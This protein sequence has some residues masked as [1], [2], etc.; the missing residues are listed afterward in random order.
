MEEGLF[1]VLNAGE[2]EQ[3]VMSLKPSKIEELGTEGWL[4]K[5]GYMQKLHQQAVLEASEH[6]EEV[7]KEFMSTYDKVPVL[8]HDAICISVWRE[9]VLPEILKIE[10][11]PKDTFLVYSV[12]F[13]EATSVSL[14][15]TVLFHS[16]S[17]EALGDTAVDLLDYCMP[18]LFQVANGFKK[19]DESTLTKDAI[20]EQEALISF[21][22]GIRC[23]SVLHYLI[24]SMDSL[25][26][27]VT[28]RM[29]THHDVPLLLVHLLE[30]HPWERD[31]PKICGQKL[32]FI[33][34]RWVQVSGEDLLKLTRVEGQVW[35]A[36]RQLLLRESCARNYEF[37]E[38]RKSQLQKV[39]RYMT[40][41]LL[42]QLSPLIDLK[43]FLCQLQIS[44]GSSTLRRPL[45]LE[46]IPE[47]RRGFLNGG[48]G[49]WQ[50]IARA[51]SKVL[52]HKDQEAVL[53][54]AQSLSSA[55]NLEV[56]ERLGGEEPKCARCGKPGLKRCSRCKIERYCGR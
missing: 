5:H 18:L 29:Y 45:I 27:A 55:Y 47:I 17:C 21:N 48:S 33:D 36:L 7:V 39:L 15:E 12:L 44:S 23:I 30:N 11:D 10:D 35:L 41:P 50:K 3:Y 1:E 14:L 26:L 8:V 32:K 54:M 2:T 24:E 46:V 38:F 13:H 51:Q 9:K 19:S 34:G 4:Q 42:D 40:D 56:L 25:P 22:V 31:N 53:R 20:K 16:D 37:S 49:K 28:S 52:F 43:Q 6:R